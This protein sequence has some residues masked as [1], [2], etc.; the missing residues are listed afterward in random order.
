MKNYHKILHILF[1]LGILIVILK[2]RSFGPYKE[3]VT[4]ML[5]KDSLKKKLTPLQYSV[6]QDDETE[7][8]FNNAYWDNKRPGIYVDIIS[9]EALFS[10]RAKYDSGSGWPSFY[11]PLEA[12]NIV[13]KDEVSLGYKRVEVRSK[14][15]N[16]HLGHLFTDGPKPTGLRY[17][18][19]SA[20][21][22]FIPAYQL[23]N[24]RYASYAKLFTVKEIA[25]S[26]D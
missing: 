21:L 13:L 12:N 18:I 1:A 10:S 4:T 7:E 14:K 9:G 26:R 5:K 25:A 6:T 16:S 22:L 23:E 19:N 3:K 2:P 8:A 24:G 15:S 20:A 11:E 17:C